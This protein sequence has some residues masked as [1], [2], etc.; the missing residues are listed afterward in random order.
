MILLPVKSPH[1]KALNFNDKLMAN[2]EGRHRYYDLLREDHELP[3]YVEGFA[4][5][6]QQST[7]DNSESQHRNDENSLSYTSVLFKSR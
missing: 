1:L 7:E 6:S 2:A 4:S 3:L 5:Y